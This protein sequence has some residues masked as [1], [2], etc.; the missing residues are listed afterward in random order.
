[1]AKVI[2]EELSEPQP[3]EKKPEEPP[4]E[5]RPQTPSPQEEPEEEY[6]Y[7][8]SVIR[9]GNNVKVKLMKGET[10]VVERSIDA[11]MNNF[12]SA[13]QEVTDRLGRDLLRLK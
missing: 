13:M 12:D 5:E 8:I 1:M 10:T 2:L 6:E 9:A 4:P 7:T 11:K 3:E